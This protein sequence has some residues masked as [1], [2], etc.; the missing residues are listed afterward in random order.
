MSGGYN[1]GIHY[2]LITFKDSRGLGVFQIKSNY[3]LINLNI[4]LMHHSIHGLNGM[5]FSN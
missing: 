1:N 3:V 2:M 5:I 4:G